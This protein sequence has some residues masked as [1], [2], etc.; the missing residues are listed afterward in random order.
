MEKCMFNNLRYVE[1]ASIIEKIALPNQ[2][3]L[4]QYT[5]TLYGN[6]E[7]EINT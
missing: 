2:T 6:S 1:I 5:D 7:F 4:V 3:I